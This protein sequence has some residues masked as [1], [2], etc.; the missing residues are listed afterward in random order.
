M[1][2]IMKIVRQITV[3]CTEDDADR[4]R[5]MDLQELH[6][7]VNDGLSI[8][9]PLTEVSCERIEGEALREGLLDIGNDGEFFS[10]MDDE[11]EC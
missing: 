10:H 11:E 5:A 7:E 6:E 3:Y 4:V 9:G 8:G 2:K 1:P